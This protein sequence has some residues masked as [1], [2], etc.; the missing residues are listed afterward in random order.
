MNNTSSDPDVNDPASEAVVAKIRRI[1]IVS[2]IIM[3]AGVGTVL[4]VIA[5]RLMG[6]QGPSGPV[7]VGAI[8]PQ[9][10]KVISA[11]AADS[12]LTVTYDQ[13]GLP[14]IVVYDLKSLKEVHRITVGG[15]Q[16][17]RP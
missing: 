1:S 15:P 17:P 14:V 3:I 12:Q 10:A 2:S 6:G 5:Y 8:D 16:V 13:G 4:A 9:G 7:R 11:V